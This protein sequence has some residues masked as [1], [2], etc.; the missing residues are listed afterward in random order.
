MLAPTLVRLAGE[1]VPLVAGAALH[2]LA[3]LWP[4]A[5][6]EAEALVAKRPENAAIAAERGRWTAYRKI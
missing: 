5:F 6:E 1:D 3:G 4:D 2:A